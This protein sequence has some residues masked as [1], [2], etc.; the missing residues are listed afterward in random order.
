MQPLSCVQHHLNV[1]T[2]YKGTYLYRISKTEYLPPTAWF[3]DDDK[4]LINIINWK[5]ISGEISQYWVDKWELKNDVV[6][7]DLRGDRT[8]ETLGK[9]MY[10]SGCTG[11]EHHIDN[12]GYIDNYSLANTV[13]RY[14]D[15]GVNGWISSSTSKLSD[16]NEIMVCK[17][18]HSGIQ[19]VSAIDIEDYL[20]THLKMDNIDLH[21]Y[22]RFIQSS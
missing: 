7:V 9:L 10:E 14:I 16:H 21:H 11:Y 2:L 20:A 17:N 13:C 18:G 5:C 12:H 1:H 22:T 15:N 19:H 3:Y 6:V 4:A 8:E